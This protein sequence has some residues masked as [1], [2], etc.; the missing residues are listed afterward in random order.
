M[1]L[2][3]AIEEIKKGKERKFDQ[4]VDLI[5]NLKGVDP[6]RDNV[7]IVVTIPHK[8]KDKNV[9]GF[10]SEK[11]KLV[12]TITEPEFKKYSDKKEMRRLVKE[13]D[14]FIAIPKLMPKV[15]T[16]F[17]KV[18]GPAGKMPS[19]QL[20]LIMQENDENIQK[21]LDK[22]ATSIKIRMKEASI[23]TGVGKISLSA[24]QL[25]Q[26]VTTVYTA[27]ENALP[28]KKESVKSVMLKTTMG[29]PVKVDM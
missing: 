19:P 7:N 27:I 6:K 20:G 5:V 18:L 4:T 28:K 17:G 25:S 10:L 11:T 1:D 24:D 26:N 14:Y 13:F 29:K 2:K 3:Q 12:K 22:I 23:K 16:A 9:A 21:T 15:A 8:F